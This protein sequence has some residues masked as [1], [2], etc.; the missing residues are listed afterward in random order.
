MLTYTS[1]NAP[2][3]S[4]WF[5]TNYSS[6]VHARKGESYLVELLEGGRKSHALAWQQSAVGRRVQV[7]ESLSYEQIRESREEKKIRRKTYPEK[8]LGI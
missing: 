3:P 2:K 8:D 5:S 4:L 7:A 1:S 6:C